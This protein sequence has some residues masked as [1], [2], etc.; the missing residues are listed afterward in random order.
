MRLDRRAVKQ[1]LQDIVPDPAVERHML[2]ASPSVLVFFQVPYFLSRTRATRQP[3]TRRL[4]H[5]RSAQL[6][7]T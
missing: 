6:P 3:Q 1:N 7:R 4:S 2:T 5:L